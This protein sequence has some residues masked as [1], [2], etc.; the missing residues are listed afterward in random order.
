MTEG[1]DLSVTPRTAEEA[2]HM[3][4]GEIIKGIILG[5][6][7]GITEFFPVSS[8]AHLILFPWFFGWKGEVDTL[9]FD[10]ALHGGTLLSL[11]VCFHRDIWDILVRDRRTLFLVVI[12]CIPAGVAGILLHHAAES[13]LRSPVIIVATLV[14]VGFLM[15]AAESYGKRERREASLF[16][17]VFIGVSQAAALVPGVSRSGITITAGLFRNLTREYAARFTFIISIPVIAGATMLEGRKLLAHPEGYH[18][19][20]VIAGLL[21]AFISGVFAIKFLLAFLRKYPL[22]LFVYYRFLLAALILSLLYLR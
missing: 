22:N 20:V 7:Q 16:D 2:Q 6:V 19:D 12:A 1:L 15:L 3:F 21:A 14:G 10:V 5:V 18:L 4:D 11:L 13:A 17:A 8:T 9:A